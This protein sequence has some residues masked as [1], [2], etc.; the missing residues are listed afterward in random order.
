MGYKIYAH[1]YVYILMQLGSLG[2]LPVPQ[3]VNFEPKIL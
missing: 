2:G 1:P 3:V